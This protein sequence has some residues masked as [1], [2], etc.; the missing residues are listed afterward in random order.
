MSISMP[1]RAGV[2]AA[3]TVLALLATLAMSA[4]PAR[5]E[6]ASCRGAS[7]WVSL[8]QA[9]GALLCLVNRERARRGLRG[10]RS[11]RRLS[12]VARRHAVD[13]VR[14]RFV[15]HNSPARGGLMQR[16]KRSGWARGR[17]SWTY[18]EIMGDGLNRGA[19]PA[20]IMRAWMRRPI[21]S[22]A[23]L[24]PRFTSMGVGAVYGRPRGSRSKRG[25]RTFVM[26]FAG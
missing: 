18:G 13:L 14:F 7:N 11:N 5:A 25:G 1:I 21:H 10:M 17:G 6:A 22:K 2:V 3:V 12:G 24:H 16:I 23:I 4:M 9:R 15:G 20:R 19:S 8:K 26:T